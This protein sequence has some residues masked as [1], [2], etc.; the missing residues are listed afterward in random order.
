MKRR[1]SQVYNINLNS[2]QFDL[3]YLESSLLGLVDV[4]RDYRSCVY[5]Y[6]SVHTNPV[7]Y[8]AS[9]SPYL[10]RNIFERQ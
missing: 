7:L 3:L 8:C 4:K 9:S 1:C 6:Q 5:D 2:Q 10:T